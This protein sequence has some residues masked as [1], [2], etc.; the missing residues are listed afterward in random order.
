MPVVAGLVVPSTPVLVPEVGRGRERQAIQTIAAYRRAGRLVQEQ[1]PDLLLLILPGERDL[2]AVWTSATGPM[3]RPF[4]RFD[5]PELALADELDRHLAAALKQGRAGSGWQER[6][7]A[8][9]PEAALAPLYF[10][11]GR[12]GVPLLLVEVPTARLPAAA[13]AGVELAHALAG[14]PRRA[15]AVAVGELSN[16]LFPGAPGGFAANAAEFD[17]RVVG[18]LE[19]GDSE[20]LLDTDD[21]ERADSGET[22]LPQLVALAR[23]LRGSAQVEVLSYALP[24]GI[25][26]LV[27]SLYRP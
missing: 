22:L 7:A 10:L 24:F 18:L 8:E 9:S 4:A 6:A 14:T 3:P 13:E 16:R 17:R 12:A 15:V 2:P 1:A 21:R 26:Y 27:A 11:A 20:S 25:G 5:A 23:A 19:A